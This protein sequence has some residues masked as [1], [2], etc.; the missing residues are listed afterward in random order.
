MLFV[1]EENV[2]KMF[3]KAGTN[4]EDGA[5]VQMLVTNP[6]FNGHGYAS[7][8]LWWKMQRH[9]DENPNIDVHLDTA[10]DYGQKVYE[11]L[12]FTLLGR[13]D[14]NSGTDAEGIALPKDHGQTSSS[15][16]IQSHRVMAM[17][18]PNR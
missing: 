8:L 4:V 1:Y 5:L 10:N 17:S 11:R 13:M 6:E 9:W 2:H 14:V 18:N 12:G 3:K 7:K 15:D 16:G